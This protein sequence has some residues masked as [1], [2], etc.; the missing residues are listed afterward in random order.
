MYTSNIRAGE[1]ETGGSQ[2]LAR[3]QFQIQRET[4]SQKNTAEIDGGRHRHQLLPY[5]HVHMYLHPQMNTYIHMHKQNPF[6]IQLQF[7]IAECPRCAPSVA[8][9]EN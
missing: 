5:T 4:L 7:S 9:Y 6:P 1:A 3:C 2:G 8:R